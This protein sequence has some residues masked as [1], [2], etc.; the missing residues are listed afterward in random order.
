[1]TALLGF[2]KNIL[3]TQKFVISYCY[4]NNLN[5]LTIYTPFNKPCTRI[6]LLFCSLL[7]ILIVSK[8]DRIPLINC[9]IVNLPCRY[10]N[11][12]LIALCPEGAGSGRRR[13]GAQWQGTLWPACVMSWHV[14]ILMLF[15]AAIKMRIKS[16][17]QLR[18]RWLSTVPRKHLYERN[19]L[20][21]PGRRQRL[22]GRQALS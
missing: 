8:W 14:G 20:L 11:R 16:N 12:N 7:Y 3:S 1:M 19:T 21:L 6:T 2:L 5:W 15:N 4:F 22:D 10:C 13:G 17:C 9:R 18:R